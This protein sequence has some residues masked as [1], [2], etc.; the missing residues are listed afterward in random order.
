VL[1]IS[2]PKQSGLQAAA[3]V[4]AAGCEVP[5]VF[6]SVHEAP[7]IVSAARDAGGRGFVAKRSLGVDLVPA[8]RAVLNGRRFVSAVI[9]SR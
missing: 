8:I 6:V 3:Q 2:L 7:E 1:D 9:G 5:I 4:R